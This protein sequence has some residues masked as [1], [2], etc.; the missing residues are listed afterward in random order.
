MI[1][2]CGVV[3]PPPPPPQFT[4]PKGKK[5]VL[6]EK[7][8]NMAECKIARSTLTEL[9]FPEIKRIGPYSECAYRIMDARGKF[10]ERH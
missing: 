5:C 2:S 9:R 1:G 10:G 8:T 6:I 4:L 7:D 3:P